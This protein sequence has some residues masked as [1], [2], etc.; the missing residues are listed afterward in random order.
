M[1]RRFVLQGIALD[2]QYTV[3]EASHGVRRW[4]TFL[5]TNKD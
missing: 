4:Y 3:T 5:G 2:I 1:P